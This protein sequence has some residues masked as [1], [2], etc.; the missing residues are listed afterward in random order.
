MVRPTESAG[1][2]HACVQDGSLPL[3]LAAQNGRLE[4]V[5][6]LLGRGAPVNKAS[7]VSAAQELCLCPLLQAIHAL[8]CVHADGEHT[9]APGCPKWP[10]RVREGAA[11]QGRGSQQGQPCA[12]SSSCTALAAA[13]V[14][15]VGIT[16]CTAVLRLQDGRTPLI[17]AAL[18]GRPRCCR[19]LLGQNRA[20]QVSLPPAAA[21]LSCLPVHKLRCWA[22]YPETALK[23]NIYIHC[24]CAPAGHI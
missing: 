11:G 13:C 2:C 10:P 1:L 7:N 3:H 24:V 15:A 16:A 6:E 23:K 17:L 12:S 19:A 4:S 5:R 20:C 21:G 8:L 9:P 14:L 18:H 22:K